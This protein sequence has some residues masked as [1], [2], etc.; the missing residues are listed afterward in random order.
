MY[1]IIL[2]LLLLLPPSPPPPPPAPPLLLPLL[3]LLLLLPIS[4]CCQH[5]SATESIDQLISEENQQFLA[6]FTATFKV[7]ATV[8]PIYSVG[9]QVRVR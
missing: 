3:L 9:V 2:C 1:R 7:S 4:L 6:M 8:L 5:P